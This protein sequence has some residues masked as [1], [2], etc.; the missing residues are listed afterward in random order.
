MS[1]G[2]RRMARFRLGRTLAFVSSGGLM[3]VT[4]TLLIAPAALG[5]GVAHPTVIKAPYTKITVATSVSNNQVGCGTDQTVIFPHF[6][7][8]TGTGGF[9]DS[10]KAPGCASLPPN[11]ANRG[12]AT[13]EFSIVLP[14]KI[15]RS[16]VAITA[17]WTISASGTEKLTAGTCV[18]STAAIANCYQFAQAYLFG[19][20]YLVDSLNG[21][22]FASSNNWVGMSNFSQND[23][24]CTSGKCTAS[25]VGGTGGSFSGSTAFTWF[26]NAT[27]LVA[28]HTYFLEVDLFGGAQTEIDSYGTHVTGGLASATL[29]FATLGNGAKLNSITVA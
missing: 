13:S 14:I 6:V 19:S 10:A 15:I 5:A 25:V 2:P 24:F 18:A 17:N 9:S 3:A 1:G 4:L 8:A 20:A 11:V 22:I 29:N 21:T 28:S 12:A 7:K 16:H 23:T 27:G 26:V